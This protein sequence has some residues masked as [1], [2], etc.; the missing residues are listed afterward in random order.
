MDGAE[1]DVPKK[2][3]SN[4]MNAGLSKRDATIKQQLVFY[5][6]LTSKQQNV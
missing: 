4:K 6:T 3:V 2:M 1:A 5:Q